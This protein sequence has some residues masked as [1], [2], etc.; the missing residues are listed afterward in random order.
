M[1]SF[2]V[3]DEVTIRYAEILREAEQERLARQIRARKPKTQ[4]RMLRNLGNALISLGQSLKTLAL[5]L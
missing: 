3:F 2:I 4:N 5:S 1:G